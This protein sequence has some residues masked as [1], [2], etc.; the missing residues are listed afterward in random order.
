MANVIQLRYGVSRKKFVYYEILDLGTRSLRRKHYSTQGK[1]GQKR[2]IVYSGNLSKERVGELSSN[3]KNLPAGV[4]LWL[5]GPNGE[6]LNKF[7][8]TNLKYLGVF[9][10]A[11]FLSKLNEGN[12]GLVWYPINLAS[13]FKFSSSSK[14]S[15]YMVA[16]L[17]VL[18]DV[19]AKYVAEITEK[20]KVGIVGKNLFDLFIKA[21]HL[22]RETYYELM[23]NALSLGDKIRSGYFIKRALRTAM[24]AKQ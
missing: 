3:L 9:E 6:W 16:G 23:S 24:S 18:V 1:F 8:L 17:P 7:E 4:E 19:H 12:F 14:F 10:E 21:S 20:Y 11:T 2:I 22:D 13:Y 15:S 5:I